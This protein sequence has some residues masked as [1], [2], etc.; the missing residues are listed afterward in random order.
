MGL[1][2]ESCKESMKKNMENAMQIGCKGIIDQHPRVRYAGLS[3]VALL[4]TELAPIAQIKFHTE[5]MPVLI[6]MMNNETLNKL[7][8]HAVST[9][10]NFVRGF[11]N[12]EEEDTE[13]EN[14]KG[15]KIL[16]KYSTQLFTTLITLLKKGITENHEP[17]QEEVMNLISIMANIIEKDFAKYYNDLMPMMLE[18]ISV[19]GMQ[20]MQQKNLR[21][22]TIETMGFMI[23]AVTDERETFN[24][25]VIMITTNL[26]NL[27][28]S[29]LSND[30][31]QTTTIK[32]TLS[33]IAF[34]LKE[35]FHQFMDSLMSTVF[36]DAKADIDIKMENAAIPSN[37]KNA[38]VT[39]KLKGL[40]G[41]QRISMNT[42]ALENKNSAFKLISMISESMGKAFTPYAEVVL[43][44]VVEYMTYPYSKVIR[45]YCM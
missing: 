6:Q 31:P 39:F 38:G 41:E 15:N 21:A 26:I 45:K 36:E 1:I 37:D 35:D 13:D 32:E 28:K 29:G 14:K 23:E 2:A 4:L 8:A 3:C 12:D 22:K 27:L 34:F 18:I 9:T 40:E 11:I 42:S 17:M 19:V 30:D 20:T 5:L 10:I 44:L 7:K 24:A 43:N 33:K 25:N 16:E